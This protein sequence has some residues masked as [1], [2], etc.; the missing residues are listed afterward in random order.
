LN[1]PVCPEIWLCSSKSPIALL[2]KF[3]NYLS[4]ERKQELNPELA[5]ILYGSLNF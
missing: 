3:N 1:L 2:A 5:S 4:L